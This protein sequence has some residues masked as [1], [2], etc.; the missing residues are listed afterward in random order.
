MKTR[1][2]HRRKINAIILQ[3]LLGAIIICAFFIPNYTKLEHTG[4]NYFAV[5][6]NDSFIGYAG[7]EA[8][9]DRC[10]QEA[11]R[12][13]AVGSSELVFAPANLSVSGEEV[14]FGETNSDGELIAAMSLALSSRIQERFH[15]SYTVKV[16]ETTVNLA[17]A[18]EVYSFLE[19]AIDDYDPNEEYEVSLNLDKTRELTVLVPEISNIEKENAEARKQEE[20]LEVT[21]TTAGVESLLTEVTTV[22]DLDNKEGFESFDY[23]LTNIGFREKIEIVE[24]YLSEDELTD[25]DTAVNLLTE[26][27]EVQQI[28][29]VK[30][31]DTLSKISNTTEIPM[32][33]ILAMN[34]ETLPTMN[35]MLHIGDELIITVPEPELSVEWTQN[36]YYEEYYDDDVRYVDNDDWYTTQTKVLQEPVQGFRKVVACVNYRNTVEEE[37]EILMQEIVSP[38]VPKIIE[39]GTKVPPTYVKPLS[40]GHLTSTFGYRKAPTAG[41]STNHKGVD[42]ATPTGTAIFA[43][44]GGKVVKAGWASGYGYVVYI[45]HPDGRQT[46]Y[47]HLSK[48]LVDV[49]DYVSQGQKIALSGSSGRSTGPHLHFEI[50]INGTHVNPL[51]YL[52]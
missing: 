20:I 51:K 4:N 8:T 28:Y 32:D 27:Q 26:N 39:R 17:S 49:G 41:A 13:L 18:E 47:A 37:K 10:L 15:R 42:W 45:N 30:S 2:I 44:C 11:R 19:R 12:S 50:L 14:W 3:S 6:L 36:K 1:A 5:T 43:S 38:A 22:I 31:G 21:K 23:G 40:G 48:I 24:S 35:S 34:S 25:L 9:I 52:D 46:R 7:D 16:N 33:T 29:V